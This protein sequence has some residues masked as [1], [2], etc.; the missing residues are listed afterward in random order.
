MTMKKILFMIIMAVK[1]VII[2]TAAK[3][4]SLIRPLI[5]AAALLCLL[6]GCGGGFGADGA[7]ADDLGPVIFGPDS[8]R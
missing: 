8:T 4:A 3:S 5:C 6:A 7:G 2:R 1:A